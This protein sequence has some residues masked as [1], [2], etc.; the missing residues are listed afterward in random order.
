[1]NIS[2]LLVAVLISPLPFIS[3]FSSAEAITNDVAYGPHFDHIHILNPQSYPLVGDQWKINFETGL[4]SNTL[5]IRGVNGTFF[6]N[7]D[8]TFVHLIGDDGIVLPSFNKEYVEFENYTGSGT[9]VFDVHTSGK[10]DLEFTYG[11]SVSYAHNTAIKLALSFSP[12]RETT[13][14]L[15]RAETTSSFALDYQYYTIV[16]EDVD[17]AIIFDIT[18]PANPSQ[19]YNITTANS[20]L[21]G[22]I[23]DVDIFEINT[24]TYAA[25]SGYNEI[26]I[27]DI[28]DPHNPQSITSITEHYS[29]FLRA[30]AYAEIDDLSYLV[31]VTQSDGVFILNVTNP[32]LPSLAS[33][34][35]SSEY[36]YGNLT[37]PKHATTAQ[38]DGHT[39]AFITDSSSTSST[40][41][42]IV[43]LDITDPSNPFLASN[44]PR[45]DTKF[46]G[47]YRPIHLETLI[48]DDTLYTITVSP[49]S[50]FQ[51]INVTTP[52]NPIH[53]SSL[54]TSTENKISGA[55]S[56][57]IVELDDTIYAAVAS[58][59]SQGVQFI[60]IT[61]PEM[62]ISRN[63][64]GDDGIDP[65][66]LLSPEEIELFQI[67]S[68]YYALVTARYSNGGVQLIKVNS[69]PI[70]F[71]S[72]N[73][74]PRYAKAGDT[75]SLKLSVNDTIDSATANILGVD[76]TSSIVINGGNLNASFTV[77]SAQLEQYATF[78]IT[79]ENAD[80]DS[81]TITENN[82]ITR[83][84]FVDTIPPSISLIGHNPEY[85]NVVDPVPDGAITNDGSPGYGNDHYF[86]IQRYADRAP[87][88]VYGL[89]VVLSV[90]LDVGDTV[91]S[92]TA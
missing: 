3:P 2:Y 47:L 83:P 54:S 82:P 69:D 81:Y 20:L 63:F 6:E 88:N 51:I 70:E 39:Y 87:C 91:R 27:F 31:T 4:H 84:I 7:N 28:S 1:M 68:S 85:V 15:L 80:G 75:L 73:D 36:G 67:E 17:N 52:T 29:D 24:A 37:Q 78:S 8:L 61:N 71:L 35:D 92:Y 42:G 56:V 25:I 49:T 38:F 86:V 53:V 21:T 10:H 14:A 45:N 33:S 19:I 11:D 59:Y 48:I 58:Q 62:P 74:H 41:T 13:Y 64:I 90:I 23:Y 32:N 77:S 46:P 12:T 26:I 57:D 72:S 40:F 55:S 66:E 43:M 60:D 16:I 76:V 22:G 89:A 34:M 50:H 65:S 30:V 79:V 5:T 44:I 18:D 9:V